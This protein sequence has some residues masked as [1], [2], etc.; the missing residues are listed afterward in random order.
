M[1]ENTQSNLVMVNVGDLMGTL[2][3]GKWI[4]AVFTAVFAAARYGMRC[5]YPTFTRQRRA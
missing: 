2:W 4:I 3:S 1:P 5:H